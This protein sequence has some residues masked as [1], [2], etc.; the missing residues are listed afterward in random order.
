MGGGIT[1]LGTTGI[2]LRLLCRLLRLKFMQLVL[3]VTGQSRCLKRYQ[4]A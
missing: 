4:Q 3:N 2:L 1:R